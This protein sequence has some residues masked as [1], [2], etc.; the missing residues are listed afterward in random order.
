M[1]DVRTI[2]E[3]FETVL[4]RI[5]YRNKT[6]SWPF[7]IYKSHQI[8]IYPTNYDRYSLFT[9]YSLNNSHIQNVIV[10]NQLLRAIVKTVSTV[11][12]VESAT[13]EQPKMILF[14]QIAT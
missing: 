10:I 11:C 6:L 13:V 1:D 7:V 9:L 2:L 3:P 14:V 12:T 4:F 8:I 5:N